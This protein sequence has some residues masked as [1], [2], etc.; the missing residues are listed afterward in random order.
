MTGERFTLENLAELQANPDYVSEA[1]KPFW[2]FLVQQEENLGAFMDDPEAPGHAD[3]FEFSH[4]LALLRMEPNGPASALLSKSTDDSAMPGLLAL[5][6]SH[7]PAQ[8]KH[9]VKIQ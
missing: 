6:R 3:N 2:A 7:A 9:T 8:S 1:L 4:I 5:L